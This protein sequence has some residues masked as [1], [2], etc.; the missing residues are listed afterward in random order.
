MTDSGTHTVWKTVCQRGNAAAIERCLHDG[1]AVGAV[2]DDGTTPLTCVINREPDCRDC[3]ECVEVLLRHGASPGVSAYTGDSPLHRAISV[4]SMPIVRSLL[5]AGAAPDARTIFGA[6]PLHRLAGVRAGEIAN[7]AMLLLAAGAPINAIDSA[8]NTP[9][10]RAA[11]EMNAELAR[12]LVASGAN[13]ECRNAFGQTPLDC[14]HYQHARIIAGGS[15]VP[16]DVH[17]RQLK[18][19]GSVEGSLCGARHRTHPP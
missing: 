16:R 10:H 11:I 8:K 15:E 12:V 4:A 18:A 13:V 19:F 14:A 6:T 1:A 7:L 17:D 9:L 2:F 5:A 3:L